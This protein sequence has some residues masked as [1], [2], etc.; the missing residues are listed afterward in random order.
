VIG[1]PIAWPIASILR[2]VRHRR[3]AAVRASRERD[4]GA[5]TARIRTGRPVSARRFVHSY[6][7]IASGPDEDVLLDVVLEGGAH[8]VVETR[9]DAKELEALVAGLTVPTVAVHSYGIAQLFLWPLWLASTFALGWIVTGHG[10]FGIL[11]AVTVAALVA[12]AFM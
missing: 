2:G 5:A 10:A 4:V 6:S 11:A 1:F 9:T 8:V 12:L 3:F 7:T